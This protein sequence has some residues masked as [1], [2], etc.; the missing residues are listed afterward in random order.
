M[1]GLISC[2]FISTVAA[3]QACQSDADCTNQWCQTVA[4]GSQFRQCAP[5]AVQGQSCAVNP[6]QDWLAKKCTAGLV[7]TPFTGSVANAG[8]VYPGTC[9]PGTANVATVTAVAGA[10]CGNNP[11]ICGATGFCRQSAANNAVY[12]CQPLAD[13]GQPCVFGSV[14]PWLMQPCLPT[15]ECRPLTAAGGVTNQGTCQIRGTGRT[16]VNDNDCGSSS[17]FCKRV[18]QQSSVKEC[19]KRGVQGERCNRPGFVAEWDSLK[20]LDTLTCALLD[21]NNPGLGGTCHTRGTVCLNDPDCGSISSFCRR[22]SSTSFTKQCYTRAIV[23]EK[24]TLPA[25]TPE[26]EMTECASDLEC[27]EIDVNNPALQGSCMP[28]KV[29]CVNDLDCAVTQF[30]K[31]SSSTSAHKQC[32]DRAVLNAQ[33]SSSGFVPEWN[34]KKCLSNLRCSLISTSNPALGGYCRDQSKCGHC[35]TIASPVCANGEEYYNSC[36]ARCE[37]IS[38]W[39]EGPCNAQGCVTN[40]D[41]KSESFFCK[42]AMISSSFKSCFLASTEGQPCTWPGYAT[43]WNQRDCLPSLFCVL[44]DANTPGLGGTCQAQQTGCSVDSDCRSSSQF[45][46]RV[47]SNSAFKAC[48]ERSSQSQDCTIGTSVPEWNVKKCLAT[49]YC[50]PLNYNNPSAGGVCQSNTF[51]GANGPN[52]VLSTPYNGVVVPPSGQI[53]TTPVTYPTAYAQYAQNY[54]YQNTYSNPYSANYNPNYN[55][56]SAYPSYSSYNTVINPTNNPTNAAFNPYPHYSAY[57]TNY[58]AYPQQYPQQ[59]PQPY[60]QQYVPAGRLTGPTQ[61]IASSAYFTC[62]RGCFGEGVPAQNGR[63]CYCDS[64]CIQGNDCCPDYQQFCGRNAYRSGL[65]SKITYTSGLKYIRAVKP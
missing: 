19:F 2:I 47:S 26:W 30:C 41:C 63:K 18:S 64:Q 22:I 15:Y 1:K 52:P 11:G 29:A 62:S 39:Q 51:Y 24:C 55:Y 44:N 46:K 35:D 25:Y 60:P 8:T 21:N 9:L 40:A 14:A 28:R 32:F 16:C 34:E 4:A 36:F 38:V 10:V 37:G 7:C 49:L 59:Y 56:A 31:R 53:Q 50:Y 61:P 42:R 57:P 65:G 13:V 3:Q 54:N 45:C 27:V 33:C 5:F 20:C 58:A 12:N 43:D 6:L 23:G 48:F 17:L